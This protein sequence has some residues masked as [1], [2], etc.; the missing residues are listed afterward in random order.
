MPL[1]KGSGGKVL[2]AWAADRDLFDIEPDVLAEVRAHG[3]AESVAER[4]AGVASV[5]VPVRGPDGAVIAAISVSG[6]ADRLDGVHR[7][8]VRDA[9]VTAAKSLARG[10]TSR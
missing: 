5:S 3:W 8:R 1:T 6:P 2:L 4:E 9:V 7:A 10:V